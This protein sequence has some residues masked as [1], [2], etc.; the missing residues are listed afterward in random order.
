MTDHAQSTPLPATAPNPFSE[1]E[2]AQA[3]LAAVVASSEDAIISKTLEGIVTS[4]NTGAGRLFGYRAD[5]IVGRSI[6][7]II[8]E[9]LRYEE[10]EILKRLRAGS[11]VDRTKRSA[12]IKTASGLRSLLT[13]SPVLDAA[14]NVVGAAKIAHDV[15]ER[16]R[17]DRALAE[18]AK[19]LE[20]LNRVGQ[21]VA[22]QLDIEALVQLVTDFRHTTNGRRIR[23]VFL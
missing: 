9:E 14:G 8:P 2:R 16:R 20:T 5:E 13:I 18:E 4:W 1:P 21:A 22:A 15:T 23:R 6:L 11:R 17:L 12:C 3:H 7:T 10:V 19:A